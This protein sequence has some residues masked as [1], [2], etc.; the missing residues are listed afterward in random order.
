MR[1]EKIKAITG[2]ERVKEKG[3]HFWGV[4]KTAKHIQNIQGSKIA[5]VRSF[6]QVP[7]AAGQ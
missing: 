1:D 3:D 6:L 7:E 4:K 5:L 2:G